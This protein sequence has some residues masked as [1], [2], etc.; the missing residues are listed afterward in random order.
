V[1]AWFFGPK[2]ENVDYLKA[3]IQELLD[4]HHKYRQTLYPNDKAFINKDMR[5]TGLFKEQ[6]DRLDKE[7]DCIG[8][9]LRANSV[10]FWSPRYNAHMSMETTMPSLIGYLLGLFHNQNNVALEASPMTTIIEG[11]VGVQLC[12]MLGYGVPPDVSTQQPNMPL[13]CPRQVYGWG[14]ITCD[15]S[16]AN[17]EAIW[18]ARNLKFY[19][20]S[21]Q[22]AIKEDGDL[23]FLSSVNF[24]IELCNGRRKQF[25]ECDTWELLNLKPSTV[26]NIPQELYDSFG[27]S[28]T[29]LGEAM[30]KYSV[31]SLGLDHFLRNMDPCKQPQLFVTTTRHYSWPKGAGNFSNF[32]Y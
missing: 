32:H 6:L 25:I 16:V 17:L 1:G 2:A 9:Q 23:K 8:K 3:K 7:L 10:P 18:A 24:S 19:P 30:E 22:L 28:Q 27:V 29:A 13:S 4:N 15:G 20:L 26:L 5:E 11:K 14:H 31:Q 12:T 21:L